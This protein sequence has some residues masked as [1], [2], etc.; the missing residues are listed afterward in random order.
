MGSKT[1]GGIPSF[2]KGNTNLVHLHMVDIPN[3]KYSFLYFNCYI[4]NFNNHKILA[5][6]HFL[7][8]VHIEKLQNQSIRTLLLN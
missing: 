5:I 8:K 4:I 3:L 1:E 7:I 2:N 6:T